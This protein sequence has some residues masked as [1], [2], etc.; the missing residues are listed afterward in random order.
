MERTTLAM[1]ALAAS[2]MFPDAQSAKPPYESGLGELMTATQIRHAKL[3][4]A[5]R[6]KKLG[7]RG[8]RDRRNQ[9]RLGGGTKVASNL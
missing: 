4:F 3:W 1:I 9:R 8:V 2:V 7:P 6:Q 5:G